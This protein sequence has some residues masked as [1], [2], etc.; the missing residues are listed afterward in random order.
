VIFAETGPHEAVGLDREF[1]LIAGP[2]LHELA[3]L[4]PGQL[5]TETACKEAQT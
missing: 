2:D 1:V 4:D 5:S 3:G